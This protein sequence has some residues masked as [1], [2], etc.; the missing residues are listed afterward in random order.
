MRKR[1]L[2]VIALSAILALGG[3]VG[4]TLSSCGSTESETTKYSVNYTTSSDYTISIASGTQYEEGATVS[5]TVTAAS[6]KVVESVT[7]NGSPLVATNGT[8]S[9]RMPKSNVTIAVTVEDE[10]VVTYTFEG[11][12]DGIYQE[13]QT[14]TA[15]ATVNDTSISDFT[16]TAT[17]GASL[18]KINEHSISLVAPGEV[19]IQFSTTFE[20]QALTDEISFTIEDSGL[21]TIAEIKNADV[22]TEVTFRAEVM[23]SGGTSAYLADSTGG[24]YVYNWSFNSDDTAINNKMWTV[25]DTVEVRALLKVNDNV[26]Q[27]EK[28]LQISNYDGGRVEGTYAIK[29]DADITPMEPI[30]LDEDGYNNLDIKDAGNLYTFKAYYQSGAPVADRAADITFKI[31]NT[32][33]TL[34][35][36]GGSKKMYDNDI[37]SLIANWEEMALEKGDEVEITTA[38]GWFYDPQFAYVSHGTTITKTGNK[39]DATTEV[40]YLPEILE[41]NGSGAIYTGRAIYMGRNDQAYDKGGMSYNAVYVADGSNYYMLYTVPQEMIDGLN[42]VPGQSII[43]WDGETADY[44]GLKESRVSNIRLVNEDSNIKTPVVPTLSETSPLT[45]TND[46]LSAKVKIEDAVV[47]EKTTDSHGNWTVLFTVNDAEYTLYLD[48]RYSD[49]TA[50]YIKDLAVGDIFSTYSF[51]SISNGNL[52]FV[53][54][55]DF[56]IEG[57]VAPVLPESVELTASKT[58]LKMGESV[59]L[60]YTCVPTTVNVTPT[61]TSS[62]SNIASVDNNGMVTGVAQGSATITVEFSNGVKDTLD[63]T[64]TNEAVESIKYNYTPAY[65]NEGDDKEGT[66]SDMYGKIYSSAVY[67]ESLSDENAVLEAINDTENNRTEDVITS[68]SNIGNVYTDLD[69]SAGIK[70]GSSKKAGSFNFTV[71]SAFSQI[72]LSVINWNGDEPKIAI[73]DITQATTINDA[74]T[75]EVLTFTFA[76]ATTD[77]SLVSQQ[78]SEG[79]FVIVGIEFIK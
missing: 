61:F 45:L 60:S 15:T 56:T 51:V 28:P 46:L 33:I 66:H 64:V 30:Q 31:G 29:V 74:S 40:S 75:P 1:G 49:L 47:T 71:S 20:G 8:Y 68:V 73:N 41:M 19:T 79:R 58:E 10:A 42:L 62:N 3:V 9:F 70:L 50:D 48:S 25:G 76:K 22:G 32:G 55:D 35:T 7:V 43:E 26:N 2:N 24:I 17:T 13:G 52:Q 16:I 34:R 21:M 63:F 11:K 12:L 78:A 53:Y 6:G 14:L 69:P 67:N 57:E 36:D 39:E 77:F 27:D 38:L 54:V 4:V 72:K 65:Y 37:D 44:G 23:V 59:Q 5:F 18:V